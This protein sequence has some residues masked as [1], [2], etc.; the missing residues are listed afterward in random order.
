MRVDAEA[1]R[2]RALRV[3]VDEQHP[4]AVLGE[5]GAQ[6]DRGRGLADAALL[7]GHRD[8]PGRAVPV[9]RHRL[10]D[11]LAHRVRGRVGRAEV[12][13]EVER[14]DCCSAE[15]R[16]PGLGPVAVACHVRLAPSRR[17]APDA[18][19]CPDCTPRGSPSRAR[20]SRHVRRV[21][22]PYRTVGV[23]AS[24]A[25]PRVGRSRRPRAAAPPSPA[26]RPASWSPRRARAAPGRPGRRRRRR[27]G[28]WRTS[29]AGCA[30]RPRAARRPAA[31]PGR[32][33]GAGCVH[34]LCRDSAPPRA[35]RNTAGRARARRPPAPAGRAPGTRPAPRGAYPPT[36]TSRVR[37][38]LPC[39]SHRSVR[40][41]RGRRRQRRPPRRS[42]RRCRTGTPAAPGR[43]ARSGPSPPATR[44]AAAPPRRRPAPWAAAGAAPAAARPG[45]VVGGQP[46]AHREAVQPAHRADRPRRGRRRQRRM[47]GVAV[48][49][50]GAGAPA[51]SR[52]RRPRP[53]SVDPGARPASPT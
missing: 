4:A 45:R 50:R 5:R 13:A 28:G 39:S 12:G 27:A 36:G 24:D 8:D 43:A 51:T 9:G 2:Q 14:A 49:Q 16:G 1:D 47:L 42:A 22:T 21:D 44:R 41:G 23:Q 6:V 25:R 20:R 11:R 31:R 33:P 17:P 48:A 34:A 40:S 46:L 38:P 32:R 7:V 19:D 53:R 35:L 26:C 10:G 37:P 29:A 18:S 3:E 30:A 52:R 15:R